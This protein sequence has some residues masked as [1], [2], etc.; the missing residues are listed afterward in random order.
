MLIGWFFYKIL[1]DDIEYVKQKI[2]I[3]I[4]V[5]LVILWD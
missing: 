5:K 1:D 3:K 2:L 4:I